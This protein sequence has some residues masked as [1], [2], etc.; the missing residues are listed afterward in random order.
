[1]KLDVNCMR[2]LTKDDYR[3]LTAVEM[4]MRNHEMVPVQLITSIAKL[5]HGGSFRILSTLLRYKLVAHTNLD[6][7]GYRLSYL[8]YDI[9]ALRSLLSRGVIQSVGSQIGVGKESDIFEAQNENGDEVVIKIHRL[10]RTSFRAVRKN[11]DYMNGKSK[12]S[13]LFMSRLAALKE[14]SFMKALFAHGFPTPIPI[15]Q[16]RHVVVMTKVSGSPMCQVKTGNM[17]GAES[18]FKICLSIL[19]RLAEHG[20]IHCDFNEFNLMLDEH[21]NVTLIDFPQMVST[22]HANAK[23]LFDRDV[24]CLIKFFGMK[25]RY[26]PPDDILFRL[27]DIVR[28]DVHIDEEVRASGFTQEEDDALVGYILSQ[29]VVNEGEQ[30]S[31]DRDEEED[32]EEEEVMGNN[33]QGLLGRV[34]E[35]QAAVRRG[36]EGKN[37]NEDNDDMIDDMEYLSLHNKNAAT[38]GVQLS[39][40]NSD[41]NMGSN[42]NNNN[43]GNDTSSGEEDDDKE[44]DNE[45]GDDV[46]NP[47]YKVKIAQ[48]KMRR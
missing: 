39:L 28:G 35:I 17:Y 6:Y 25:M 37:Y 32:E 26:T 34:A 3:V 40:R 27:E 24:N 13:W 18:I 46:L 47:E 23:E 10:G 9:L 15:D 5:R 12:A 11:R 2:Y 41:N 48:E 21:G 29:P 45:N 33:H 22:S 14:Y 20:L 30:D 7:N 16:N 8:G 31:Y 36:E 43:D 1:M 4:G 44:E 19:K 42:S 38:T